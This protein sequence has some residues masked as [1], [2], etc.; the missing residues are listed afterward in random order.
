MAKV[1]GDN[2][3]DEYYGE[4]E[5]DQIEESFNLPNEPQNVCVE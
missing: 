5:D 2:H 3:D 1:G 4:P